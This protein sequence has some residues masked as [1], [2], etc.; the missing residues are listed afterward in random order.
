MTGPSAARRYWR[1]FTRT[2]GV[3]EVQVAER[4]R[5]GYS[6]GQRYWAAFI[7]VV[8]PVAEDD[9]RAQAPISPPSRAGRGLPTAERAVQ[10]GFLLPDLRLASYRASPQGSAI[11]AAATPDGLTEFYVF[12]GGRPGWYLLEVV[13]RGAGSLPAVVTV[14]YR[15]IEGGEQVLLVP[16]GLS[17]IGA[18]SAQVRLAG[19][20]DSK[21]WEVSEP[22]PASRDS[23]WDAGTVTA[24]AKAAANEATREAWR[25]VST[26]L[27]P[28]LQQVIREALR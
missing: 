1:S 21:N 19:V 22:V 26:M 16:L 11:A 28:D 13:F 10:R 9:G 6:F 12:P 8:L 5:V 25:Q 15:T 24:S 2:E 7:G 23:A 4:G 3:P 18:P 27:T 14:R 20:D 17:K